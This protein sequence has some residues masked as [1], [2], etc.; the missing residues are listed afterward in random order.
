MLRQ[1]GRLG[2]EQRR[3]RHAVDVAAQRRRRRV[4]VAVR[5]DPQQADRQVLACACA[6]SA[7]AATDPAAEAVIAA[8][9]ERHRAFVERRERRLIQPSGRP[10]RC[11]GCISCARRAAPAFRE[12][13]PADRPC[14]R[15][16]SRARRCCS[17]SPAMR[18]ADG[19]MST[20]RRPPPRSSGTPM[21]WTDFIKLEV[22]T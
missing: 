11:R 12:S 5:V 15:R 18:N 20:P 9:H 7:A 13:A 17:P 2:S 1:L 21:M 3:E 10:S 19:P 22:R 6:Q 14:R 4:H 16:C 8:E